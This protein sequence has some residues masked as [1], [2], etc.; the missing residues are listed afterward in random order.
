M[1]E[2]RGMTHPLAKFLSDC[3]LVK[4]HKLSVSKNNVERDPGCMIA[5]PICS[6]GPP[7]KLLGPAFGVG[8]GIPNG[9]PRKG[10]WG[11][12]H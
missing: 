1:D 9:K 11:Q 10:C 6:S 12:T 4:L 7:P 2:T 8:H 3:E 5:A